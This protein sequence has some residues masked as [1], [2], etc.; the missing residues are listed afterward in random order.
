MLFIIREYVVFTQDFYGIYCKFCAIGV[1]NGKFFKFSFADTNT[2][3]TAGI[4]GGMADKRDKFSISMSLS[5][6]IQTE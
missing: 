6:S 4:R 2:R 5:V 1:L 3:I